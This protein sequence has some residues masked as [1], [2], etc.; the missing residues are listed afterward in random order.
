MRGEL[1]EGEV[2][3]YPA[4][5]PELVW[6]SLVQLQHYRPRFRRSEP[7]MQL[8]PHA[9]NYV[10]GLPLKRSSEGPPLFILEHRSAAL[11]E[12]RRLMLHLY[13]PN[14]EP[15]SVLGFDASQFLLLQ[16]AVAAQPCL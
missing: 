11:R 7:V 12:E 3:E 16:A 13:L 8:I 2:V 5:L 14:A 15:Q 6:L 9:S 10:I 1:E 4:E